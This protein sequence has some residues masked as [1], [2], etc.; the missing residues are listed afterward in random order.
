MLSPMLT[1]PSLPPATGAAPRQIVILLH[2]Y[3]SNGADMIALAP[4]WRPVL[5]DALFL[6]PNAPERC[7]G[8]PGG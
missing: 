8:L 1:G 2:G 4:M 3:G 5:P 7:P 6:A